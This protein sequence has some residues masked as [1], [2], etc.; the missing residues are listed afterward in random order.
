MFHVHVTHMSCLLHAEKVCM[1]SIGIRSES[2]G[3]RTYAEPTPPTCT[4]TC[5]CVYINVHM[6]TEYLENN[7]QSEIV[8]RMLHACHA[9]CM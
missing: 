6:T 8:V 5:T 3:V 9:T 1:L 2:L 4:Y 7:F